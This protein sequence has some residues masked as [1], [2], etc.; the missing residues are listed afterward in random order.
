MAAGCTA[1]ADSTTSV[2][3]TPTSPPEVA[4]TATAPAGSTTPTTTAPPETT[5]TIGTTTTTTAPAGSTTTT[6]VT[7]TTATSGT[8][9][10]SDEGVQA[11]TTWVP[12]GTLEADAVGSIATVLGAPT[13]DSGWTDSFSVY[14]TCPAPE[15]RG[16]H[17]GDFVM[18][19]TQADTDF[20]S[21]GVPHFFAYYY[22]GNVPSLLTTEGIGIGSTL[23]TLKA[24]YGGSLFTIDE[25]FF[26]PNTGSWTFD[27]QAWTGLWGYTTGQSPVDTVTS[28]GG[29]IGCG[30]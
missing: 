16:V 28:I 1:A 9:A 29:G 10:L 30:E 21:G 26:D 18:L 27:M 22:T 19:L 7:T 4:T 11:G 8:V 2:S 12:F 25:A 5:T 13:D 20:W 15:V 17:W 6:P 24:A 3:E 14:G 23:A